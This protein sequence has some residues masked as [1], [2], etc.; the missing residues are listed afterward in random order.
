MTIPPVL[1]TDHRRDRLAG[2]IRGN[3]MLLFG[4][5]SIAWLLEIVDLVSFEFFD[6]FGIQPRSLHGLFGIISAPFLH[7]GFAHLASNTLPFL[8]LGGVVLIGGRKVFVTATIFIIGVGGAALWVLGPA[9]TNHV[10]ASLLI[11]GYLGLLLARGLFE[12]SP[13]WV[14]ISLVTL[15]LYGGMLVGVLPRQA[16]V[17]WQGHLF[18]FIAGVLAA[19]VMFTRESQPSSIY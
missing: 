9:A 19:R 8:I 7:L 6:Q 12:K 2:A 13:F 17:S 10:G 5:V 15:L 16:G 18:G 14:V 11:F 1:P 3:L 4:A